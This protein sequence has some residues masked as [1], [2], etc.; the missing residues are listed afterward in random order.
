VLYDV[1]IDA[2]KPTIRLTKVAKVTASNCVFA[3]C[4][5]TKNVVG[6]IMAARDNAF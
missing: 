2:R 6:R 1:Y 4:D 3:I 5:R